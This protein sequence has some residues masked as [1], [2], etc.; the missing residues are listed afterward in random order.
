[1][2]GKGTGNF[3]R[4]CDLPI[5]RADTLPV[6]VWPKRPIGRM[7][8]YPPLS[9]RQLS[10]YFEMNAK[11]GGNPGDAADPMKVG[12]SQRHRLEEGRVRGLACGAIA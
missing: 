8:H 9:H 7:K 2:K 6:I 5:A 1:V 4:F 10:L 12:L 3:L 11:E